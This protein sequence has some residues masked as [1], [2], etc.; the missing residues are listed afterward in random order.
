MS[1]YRRQHGFGV[2]A[3]HGRRRPPGRPAGAGRRRAAGPGGDAC[4]PA[5]GLPTRWG[6]PDLPPGTTPG[7]IIAAMAGDKKRL[8]GRLRF[9]LP[10]APGDVRVVEDV[11]TMAVFTVLEENGVRR[12]RS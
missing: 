7:P 3:G 12:M 9:V 11:P 4:S 2:A 10:F 5:V 6:G 8:A 1:G